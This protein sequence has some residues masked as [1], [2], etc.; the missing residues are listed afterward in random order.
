[1]LT[2]CQYATTTTKLQTIAVNTAEVAGAATFDHEH[3]W[4]V[5]TGL[6]IK[7]ANDKVSNTSR[8]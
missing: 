4:P 2:I 7:T 5:G 3:F 6:K 8:P 1:M